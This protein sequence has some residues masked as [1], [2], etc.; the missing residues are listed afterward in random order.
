MPVVPPTNLALP[1]TVFWSALDVLNFARMLINDQQGGIGGQ[2]L[3]DD[4]AYTWLLLNFAYAKLCNQLEDTNVEAVT[5]AE[6]IVGP[7]APAPNAGVDPN[8]QVRLGYDGYWDGTNDT[9]EN[10]ILPGDM[11]EPTQIWERRSGTNLPFTL[12]KQQLGGLQSRWGFQYGF[13]S[14]GVW[15]FRG[16]NGV[17]AIYFPG[18]QSA[19][20][21]KI[22]YIPSL[23]L[24]EMNEDG[25]Y[26]QVPLLRAGEA[27]AYGVAYMWAQIRGAANTGALKAEY[28]NQVRI[29]SNKSSKRENGAITRPRGYGFG[30]RQR[31]GF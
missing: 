12:M 14:F 22:R 25:S 31:G 17:P 2:E 6:A 29:V 3:S 15:E 4:Q 19:V 24:L 21:I 10:V 9:D 28:D 18:T 23:S 13:Q 30:R 27:L 8:V 16:N 7:L 11:L 5:Y 1:S 20:E 26:P